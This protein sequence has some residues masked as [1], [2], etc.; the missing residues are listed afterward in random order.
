MLLYL[1]VYIVHNM[2]SSHPHGTAKS[3]SRPRQ[4]QQDFGEEL[5]LH[6]AVYLL[7][8]L[9]KGLDDP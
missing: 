2:D 4:A 3:E 7:L 6:E 8:N 9:Q 5:V 1:H